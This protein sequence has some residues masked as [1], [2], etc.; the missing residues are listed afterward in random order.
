M[1]SNEENEEQECLESN[2]AAFQAHRIHLCI[3]HDEQFHFQ[4][5]SFNLV[6]MTA[7]KQKNKINTVLERKCT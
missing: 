6:T 7:V 2:S 4:H 3:Q 5:I 1:N